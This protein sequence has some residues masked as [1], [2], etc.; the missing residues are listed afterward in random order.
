MTSFTP[1]SFSKGGSMHQ[2]QPPAKV[3]FSRCGI[4]PAPACE[5]MSGRRSIVPIISFDNMSVPSLSCKSI[6]LCKQSCFTYL[7]SLYRF[8]KRPGLFQRGFHFFDRYHRGVVIDRIDLPE[9]PEAFI[10][11][12]YALHPF[13]CRFALVIAV[14]RED[15][16]CRS[17]VLRERRRRE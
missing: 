17:R 6:I 11:S 9:V 3:A 5:M 8:S 4:L 12:F 1:S 2:K 13:Q 14:H 10:Y 16:L 7:F 15:G